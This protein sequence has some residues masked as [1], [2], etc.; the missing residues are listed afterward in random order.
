[1]A[2]T[3]TQAP[4][5]TGSVPPLKQTS[6]VNPPPMA[7]TQLGAPVTP[8]APL[9]GAPLQ[10]P[11]EERKALAKTGGVKNVGPQGTED[12]GTRVP[13]IALRKAFTSEGRTMEKGERGT[14]LA[15]DYNSTVYERISA[16]K[17]LEEAPNTTRQ[18]QLVDSGAAEAP[19]TDE[20]TARNA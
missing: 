6:G 10:V 18:R 2:D 5:P 8:T 14:I 3:K 9:T 20:E 7:T 12:E 11:A 13:V 4:K 1:M 19:D 17:A 16:Q 15:K